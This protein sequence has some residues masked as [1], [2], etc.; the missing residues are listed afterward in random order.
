MRDLVPGLVILAASFAPALHAHGTQLGNLPERPFDALAVVALALE[1]LPLALRRRWPLLSVALVASGFVLDQLRAYHLVSGVALALSLASTGLHLGRH[2]RTTA[3][4]LTAAYLALAVA[5]TAQGSG[6]GTSGFTTFFLLG[7]FAWAAGAWLRAARAGEEERRRLAAEAALAAE[8]A[9]L[10]RELHDVVTHHVTA[11]VVQAQAARYLTATP[12]RLEAA[13]DAIADTGRL[14]VSDLRDLLHVLDPGH[15]TQAGQAA[16]VHDIAV[17][18]D[19]ARRAGQPVELTVEPGTAVEVGS[20]GLTAYR[21][22]QE[23]LTNAL[24]HAHG[25]RTVVAVH[26]REEEITVEIRTDPA[27]APSPAPAGAGRGLAGLRERVE[28][29]AGELSAGP[30]PDGGFSVRARIPRAARS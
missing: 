26:Q 30:R 6:E 5:L 13:L 1:C 10:A 19:Q 24:K 11:M 25:S 20:A 18:V 16:P 8:R 17:L 23:A 14:A 27:T 9:R 22:V 28:A 21:V 4:V 2:R 7:A 3:A 15:A 29:L 12:D